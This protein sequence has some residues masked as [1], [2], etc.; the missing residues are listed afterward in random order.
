MRKPAF[1][2]LAFLISAFIV[3][4]TAEGCSTLFYLIKDRKYLPVTERLAMESNTFINDLAGS[5]DCRYVDTLFPHPYLAHVHH[6]NQPCPY[7]FTN[8]LGLIGREY[9]L[10]NDLT[11]FSILLT[12]GS[13][14]AQLGQIVQ[15]HPFYLEE[16]LNKHFRPPNGGNSF[17]VLNGG[18]GAWKQPQQA[19][20]FLLY[21]DAFDAVVTLDG[22]N[23]HFLLMNG[24]ARMELPSNNFTIVNP[25][26]TGSY[27]QLAATWLYNQIVLEVQKHWITSHS[28]LCLLFI[29][30]SR[31]YLRGQAHSIKANQLT[32]IQSIFSLPS[33]FNQK[34]RRDFNMNQYR[35]YIRR[36]NTIAKAEDIKSAFF[37]QPCPALSKTL[38]SEEKEVV[39]EISYG[40]EYQ[41]MTNELLTLQNDG[42]AIFSLLQIFENVTETVYADPIHFR[43]DSSG[44][45]LGYR[46]MAKALAEKLGEAWG[47]ER[48]NN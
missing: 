15:D 30:A 24:T 18:D 44:E 21:G 47:L 28:F 41:K 40:P 22:F 11:K 20:L 38:T 27:R 8:N 43:Q 39:G 29:D 7:Q 6:K 5:N 37:I 48:I 46:T 35:K 19:I 1:F 4:L 33:H 32:T 23:E 42:I 12:G 45:S 3:L 25:M 16:E 9:P 2:I 10:E 13:T 14:A 34:Q 31:S 17:L 36:I 26:A